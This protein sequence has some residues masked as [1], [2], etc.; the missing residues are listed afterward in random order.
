MKRLLKIAAV[1]LLVLGIALS[2]LVLRTAR[3]IEQQSTLD[4]ARAAD[5]ILILGAAEYRGKPSP[6]LRGRLDHG[7]ELFHARKAPLILTT[8]GAGGD[9]TFTEG[10]VGRDYLVRQGVPSEAILVE[11]EGETTMH[12]IAAAGEI[13][14]RMD[15]KSCIVVSDGYHIYRTKK[16][17]EK[18]GFEVYGSPRPETA[19]NE[20]RQQWLYLRQAVGYLLWRWGIPI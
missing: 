18:L 12:S 15:L 5:V 16:M 10:E 9:P 13:M 17:L 6:V 7:L 3:R 20:S 4:E 2:A 8:G 1:A 11:S 19:H 14:R